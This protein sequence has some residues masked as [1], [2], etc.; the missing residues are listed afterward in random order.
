M[1]VTIEMDIPDETVA[2]IDRAAEIMGITRNEFIVQ[3]IEDWLK[4]SE[5]RI[6]KAK[7]AKKKNQ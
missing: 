3:A 1:I 7:L 6:K 2:E 5:I 4:E